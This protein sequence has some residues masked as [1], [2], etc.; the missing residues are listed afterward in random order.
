MA[1]I[2]LCDVLYESG[3]VVHI[4]VEGYDYDDEDA[5][6]LEES[7]STSIAGPSDA[8][9]FNLEIENVLKKSAKSS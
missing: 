2:W 5:K 3:D 8:P 1:C 6:I 7:L 9:I 4:A